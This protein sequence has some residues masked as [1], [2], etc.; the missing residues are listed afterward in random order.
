[1]E[2]AEDFFGPE[3]D[4]A[5]ARIAVSEFDDGDALRPEEEDEGDDP[6]PDGDAAVGG[7]GRDDVE[8]E[9]GYDEE[10]DEVAASEGADELGVCGLGGGGQVFVNPQRLKPL[11]YGA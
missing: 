2:V 3:V 4:A 7:D 5:F 1:V 8:V 6:E 9:D 10:E 11:S